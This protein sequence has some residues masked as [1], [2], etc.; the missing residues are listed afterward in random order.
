MARQSSSELIVLESWY[1]GVIH[2]YGYLNQ[3]YNSINGYVNNPIGTIALM[4]NLYAE[5]ACS[6]NRLQGDVG[7]AP[8]SMSINYTNAV[9]DL[10]YSRAQFTT[11]QKGYGLAQWT[12]VARKSLYYDYAPIQSVG[13]GDINRALGYLHAELRGDY[14]SQGIDFSSTLSACQN[15]TDLHTCTDYVLDHFENP[16]YPNYSEREQIADDLWEYFFGTG[17]GYTIYVTVIGNGTAYVVPTV[18]NTGDTYDLTVTPAS[19]ESLIDIV[20]TEISTGQYI[21]I[22]VQIGT[23]TVPFNSSSNISIVVTFSGTPPTPP[24]YRR[25]KIM[26]MPIWMYPLFRKGSK[27][28][29]VKQ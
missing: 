16:R 3:I 8:S 29:K 26:G 25:Q 20:A 12:I 2:D 4:A 28:G 1:D 15:A 9:N 11:D 23:Q 24:T 19:G 5:S 7:G 14:A 17:T 10:S 13:I 6:P 27:Y 21:A 22:P 18:V